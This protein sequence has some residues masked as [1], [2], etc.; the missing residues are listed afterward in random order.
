MGVRISEAPEPLKILLIDTTHVEIYWNQ[1]LALNGGMTS[2][3]HI[4]YKGQE[5]P[6][7]ER[8][9]SEE[10][11]VGT[12]Y[13]P[14]KKRTTVSLEQPVGSEAVENM[15]IWIEKV[16]NARGMTVNSDKRYSV[17]WEP[18]YT[19]FSKT[20][21][22]IVIKSN[23]KVSDRA[24]EM[25]V[26]IMDTMLEK[27]KAAAEKMIEFGAELAIYPLGEDAYDIPEHRVG[28]LYMHRYVEGYGGVIENPISSISE[29]NVL[30]ILEG[31]HATKY[32]EELILAHEFAH[33]IH[34]IGVEHLEDRTLA[35]QFRILYQHAKN[36]GKWPNTY[37]ISNYEEYF[38]TLTTI[39][40][41][42]M[43]EGKDGQWDGIRG[44]VNT[45]EELMRYDREAYE[46]FKEFYPDKGFPIPWNETKNLYDIDGNVYGKEA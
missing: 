5:L 19:K 35:E 26:A 38:A 11:H 28:C 2:A 33:G 17:T 15:E 8:T 34:L 1:E 22:G 44:P 46:F 4:L 18:Y 12:V 25:A 42:V 21:C 45:R 14:K 10:W 41:N 31:E 30:R 43:E 7:H 20:D 40:F 29:A 39:W 32:R 3:Y 23:D 9:D 37:A 16:A 36:A 24:H 6:L 13:E 27:Q